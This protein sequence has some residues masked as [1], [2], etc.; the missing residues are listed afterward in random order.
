MDQVT[1]PTAFI[2]IDSQQ[3]Q[4]DQFNQLMDDT[5]QRLDLYL[6]RA[7][8]LSNLNFLDSN[9]TEGVLTMPLFSEKIQ[10]NLIVTATDAL[11]ILHSEM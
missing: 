1:P 2:T 5:S 9:Q 8:E 7:I 11:D 10:S 4:I 6:A 3:T